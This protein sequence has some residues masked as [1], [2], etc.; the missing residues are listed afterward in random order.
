MDRPCDGCCHCDF[1]VLDAVQFDIKSHE[2]G[3]HY[4]D[5]QSGRT[6]TEIEKPIP[7]IQLQG[8][9][10]QGRPSMVP[11]FN[12]FIFCLIGVRGSNLSSFVGVEGAVNLDHNFEPEIPELHCCKCFYGL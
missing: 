5:F 3:S 12:I 9:I 1:L 7:R 6:V 2:R 10:I 4:R 8:M 11:Y